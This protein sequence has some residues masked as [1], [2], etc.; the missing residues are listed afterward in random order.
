MFPVINVVTS[1]S[2]QHRTMKH[3]EFTFS[4]LLCFLFMGFAFMPHPLCLSP[5]L[6][7]LPLFGFERTRAVILAY[8][9]WGETNILT[10]RYFF[11]LIS[12]MSTH[13]GLMQQDIPLMTRGGR[14]GPHEGMSG[15]V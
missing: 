6:S 2:D 9:G 13:S 10:L 8:T 11:F 1:V 3:T 15:W 14:Y 4:H 5:I 12:H 7:E